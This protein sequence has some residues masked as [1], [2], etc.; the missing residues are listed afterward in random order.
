MIFRNSGWPGNTLRHR[1]SPEGR[2]TPAPRGFI[3]ETRVVKKGTKTPGAQRPYRGG[4]GKIEN[5]IVTVHLGYG[6]GSFKTLLDSQLFLPERWS[7]D[8]ERCR[9][10]DIPD[11]RVHRSQDTSKAAV[12]G[13]GGGL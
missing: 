6:H 12:M 1:A 8:P 10:V 9:A 7:D 5:G 2:P 11:E 4:V 3:D 13:G